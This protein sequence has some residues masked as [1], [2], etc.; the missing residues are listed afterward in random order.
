MLRLGRT[1]HA[2]GAQ[3]V[4]LEAA[5]DGGDVRFLVRRG[6]PVCTSGPGAQSVHQLGGYRVQGRRR[7]GGLHTRR[8]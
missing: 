2:K 4:K 1:S 5:T 8:K 7:C 6:I 3:V